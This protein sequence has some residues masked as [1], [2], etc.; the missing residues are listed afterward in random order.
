MSKAA[1]ETYDAREGA[2]DD[3]VLALAIA[4]FVAEHSVPGI[5]VDPGE[6]EPHALAS[7]AAERREAMADLFP[8]HAKAVSQQ[9]DVVAHLFGVPQ[10]IA[11]G[12]E[13]GRREVARHR[14]PSQR[15]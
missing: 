9:L 7:L 3:L 15:A 6:M 2:F 4:L 8:A 1:N 14:E 13:H 11:V 5:D 12:H 10:E